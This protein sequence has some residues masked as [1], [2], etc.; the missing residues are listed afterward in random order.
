M[1]GLSLL[2]FVAVF[3]LM[4][5]PGP[6]LDPDAMS[7]LGAASSWVRGH[8][9]RIPGAGWKVADTT[10]P[11]K[12]FPP[13]YPS[14][15]ALGMQGARPAIEAAR[16][17]Q[18]A[19][20]AV[21]VVGVVLALDAA[22][23]AVAGVLAVVLLF[24]T[25]AMII[26]HA[27]VLSEP[28]YLAVVALMTW[29][30]TRRERTGARPWILGGLAALGMLTRYAGASLVL[31]AMLDGAWRAGAWR[32]RLRQSAIAALVPAAAVGAWLLE[33]S[34]ERSSE[35]VRTTALY[36]A[37]LDRT[38]LD[39]AQ[40][41]RAWLA[42]G[43]ESPGL[44]S[45]TAMAVVAALAALMVSV[46]RTRCRAVEDVP[47]AH[48]ATRDVADGASL[49]HAAALATGAPDAA[50][51]PLLRAVALLGGT[52]V[53][54]VGAS[55]LLADGAIPLDERIL[56]P[57]G[58]VLTM[59]AAHLVVRWAQ[60][61]GWWRRGAVTV[62]LLAWMAGAVR[63]SGVWVEEYRID[64]GDL[65]SAR[66]R[67]SVLVTYAATHAEVLYSNQPSAI[68]FHTGRAVHD[69]PEQPDAPTI[70]A[71]RDK[72]ARDHGALLAFSFPDADMAVTDALVRGAG[73]VAVARDSTGTVWRMP[74]DSAAS[75]RAY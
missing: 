72:I 27:S 44:A 10:A 39:G 56:A 41:V 75:A 34:R 30:L 17:V 66:W 52:Y 35:V 57:L 65:A 19:S 49:A 5:A 47:R 13:G 25:P 73:L 22:G 69:V 58:L 28:L 40:T 53:L 43:L 2:A 4:A 20:A 50:P 12:H 46:L 59:G 32:V 24:V 29:R 48:A 42:P 6:G 18:A 63:A 55:R 68:W 74:A 38:L 9:L 31:A 67:T 62:A 23:S 60:E 16:L 33:R 11:L 26:V 3:A 64:G 54:V 7:Y 70:A 15:I 8:G 36:L 1:A 37:G 21:T 71:F 45:V 61:G 14:A 51:E